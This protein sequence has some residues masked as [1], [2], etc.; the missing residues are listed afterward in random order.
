MKTKILILALTLVLLLAAAGVALAQGGSVERSR[1]VLG[2][3]ASDSASGTGVTLRATLGQPVVGVV[4]SGG[5]DVTLGHRRGRVRR[6]SAAGSEVV[7][8]RAGAQE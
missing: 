6:L 8:R 3:G 5:G 7:T 4:T 2:G 1:G